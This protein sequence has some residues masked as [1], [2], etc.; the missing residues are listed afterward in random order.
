VRRFTASL[1]RAFVRDVVRKLLWASFALPAFAVAGK[2]L[3]VS[4]VLEFGLAAA[5]L[6]PLAWLISEAT[7]Q[8][9]KQTG[10]LIGG[11]LNAT[12]G[13]ATELLVSFFAISQGLFEVVRGSLTGS[14]ISNVLLVLGLAMVLGP[15][16]DLDRRALLSS[17]AL[18]G[19]ATVG[20]AVAALP[21]WQGRDR[22]EATAEYGWPVAG[23][24][25]VIYLLYSLFVVRRERGGEE[26]D[27]E[28]EWSLRRSLVLLA[29]GTLA[30]GVLAEALTGSIG[31]F[32]RTLGLTE[33]FVAIVLVALAGN[34]AEHGAGI[35][36]AVR[37]K[38]ELG[39]D[40][41]LQSAGQVA[42]ILIPAIALL[43]W[44]VDPLPLAFHPVEIGALAACTL[45]PAL[46]LARGRSSTWRG[47]ALVAAYPIVV[48]TL[49]FTH[50]LR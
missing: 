21:Y 6:I 8:A 35:I 15:A 44:L 40:V 36:V 22:G 20:F 26:G 43:S 29:V 4:A 33:F 1:R 46:L 38:V 18:I 30:T 12:F 45:L 34:A 7:E 50:G 31:E 28:A 47:L 9:G 14:V 32:S 5:G 24:L 42:A 49:L 16:A 17:I 2:L 39:V 10:P 25:I 13:N 41:A 27:D 19:V 48:V 3:H 23:A 37:G 11:L